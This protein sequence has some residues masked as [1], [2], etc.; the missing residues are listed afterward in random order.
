MFR[1]SITILGQLSSL[2]PSHRSWKIRLVL[3]TLWP[4]VLSREIPSVAWEPTASLPGLACWL[5]R[6]SEFTSNAGWCPL[7]APH[8]PLQ[9]YGE[10]LHKPVPSSFLPASNI[11]R[12][13]SPISHLF[14]V[15]SNSSLSTNPFPRANKLSFP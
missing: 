13:Q 10:P 1:V 7:W 14:F 3:P 4:S 9:S 11:L 6:A 12:P 2:Y 8:A 5:A 15:F